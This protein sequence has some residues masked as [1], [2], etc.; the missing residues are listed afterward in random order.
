MKKLALIVLIIWSASNL[1]AQEAKVKFRFLDTKLKP[2]RNTKVTLTEIETREELKG[3]TDNNGSVS[4]HITSGKLWQID[5]LKIKNYPMWRIKMP[6]RGSM[7]QKRTFTYDVEKYK[8]ELSPPVNRTDIDLQIISSTANEQ[9]KPT[10][11]Q[12]IGKVILS[13]KNKTPL[14]NFTVKLFSKKTST[15]YTCNTDQ[16]GVAY[17]QLPLNEIY[18]IEL[19]GIERYNFLKVPKHSGTFY[20]TIPF[21]PQNFKEQKVGN[22]ITQDLPANITPT[23]ARHLVSVLYKVK[24]KGPL[25]NKDVHLKD[26]RDFEYRAKTNSQGIAKFMLPKGFTYFYV[27]NSSGILEERKEVADL[28][29]AFGIGSL[30][31]T[32]MIDPDIS[33]RETNVKFVLPKTAE[34]FNEFFKGKNLIFNNFQNNSV[35]YYAKSYLCYDDE[36]NAVGIKKGLLMTSGSVFKA[37]G[38]NDLPGASTQ[39]SFYLIN[40]LPKDLLPKEV[41]PELKNE[42]EEGEASELG[43]GAY[44]LCRLEFNVTPQ[45]GKIVFEFVFASEEYPEYLNFDDAFGI[46]VSK[47]GQKSEKNLAKVGDDNISVSHVNNKSH[48]EYYWANDKKEKPSYKNWQYDGFTKKMRIEL[49]V[50]AGKA[51]NIKLMIFD[52]RDGIYDSGLFINFWSE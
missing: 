18:D 25:T 4:F 17:F 26:D 49:P 22:I 13:R 9:S 47:E 34:A 24:G 10:K 42:F 5:F 38:P 27:M 44:D 37:I 2:I 29:Y 52:R 11:E 48:T 41:K 19:E 23:S 7:D 20:R 36:D 40:D 33:P 21:E 31:R 30:N 1:F 45:K 43:Q 28:K 3:K 16:N 14:R 8:W 39:N 12:A 35:P 32:V 51:H 15:L 50:E 46:F 6:A